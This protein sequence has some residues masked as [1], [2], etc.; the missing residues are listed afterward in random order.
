MWLSFKKVKSHKNVNFSAGQS[1]SL[2]ITKITH[3]RYKCKSN[4]TIDKVYHM[5]M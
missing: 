2:V 5:G 3:M 4:A 1:Q